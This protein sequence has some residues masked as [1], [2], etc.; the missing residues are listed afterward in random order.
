MKGAR[1]VAEWRRLLGDRSGPLY[2]RLLE[3]YGAPAEIQPHLPVW[4]EALDGFAGSFSADADV[5]IARACGRVNLLGMHIDHRGG[6]VNALAVGDTIFV[7]QPRDDDLVVL[8][9]ADP[10]FEPRQFRISD[11]L[12][13]TRIADWDAWTMQRYQERL[14]AGTQADW[15][16]YVGAGLLYLQHLNTAVDGTFS[17][18]LRGMNVFVAGN[19]P[20][21]AGLS[22]SS[23]IVVATM[24]ACIRA[25]GLEMSDA[26]LA[27]AGQFA[28]WYVGTRGGGGDHAAIKFA[29][30]GYLAHIGSFPVTVDTV[31]LPQDCVA[32]LCNS[33]VVAA[34]TAGARNLFNQRVAGYELGLL[35]LRKHFPQHAEKMEHLRDVN[36]ATLGV[37]EGE[38]YQMLRVLP[39]AAGRD[40]LSQALAGHPAELERI[41]RSHDPVPG[42]YHVRQVCLYGIAECL[43]SER[44]VD[45]LRAGDA[46]GFGELISLSHD[47]D[48]ITH[49]VD[50]NRVPLEKLLPD[51]ELDRL[52][53]DVRSSDPARQG[54]ARLHRQPGGYDASCEE[55]DIMVDVALGVSGVFG[56]GLVGAGLGGCIVALVKRDE[57]DAVIAAMEQHYYR[58]RDL[59]TVARVCPGVGGSGIIDIE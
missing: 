43:R 34:K 51:A 55:L 3:I 38:I 24:E 29:K 2:D 49:L 22:S 23:S 15:S 4:T 1:L 6:A 40:E 39:E 33:L 20:P 14:A 31:P 44:A 50:G 10:K 57:A 17:P 52:A 30:R 7:V 13:K 8:R 53:A 27:E 41:F 18:P 45:L 36:P 59:P 11:E 37:D 19:V 16:N 56:A 58:P 46:A 48:R 21:A 12:P 42:G 28:E 26:E 32:V 5:I 54:A 9:N 25:S 47:G 35:L